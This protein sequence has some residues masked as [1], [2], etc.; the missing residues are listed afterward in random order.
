MKKIRVM[1]VD[2]EVLAIEHIQQLIP[3]EDLGYEIVCTTTRPSQAVELAQQHQPELIIVDIVMPGMDGMLLSKRIQSSGLTVKIVLLTSVK[4]FE[5]AKEAVKLGL[6]NYWVK[7]EMDSATLTRELESLRLEIEKVRRHRNEERKRLLHD[8]LLGTSMSN[9]QWRATFKESGSGLER[10]HMIILQPDRPFPL[11]ASDLAEQST[12]ELN[13]EW[14]E[15]DRE[16]LLAAIRFKGKHFVLLFVDDGWRGEG[17]IREFIEEKASEAR[18]R[19]EEIAG[20]TSSI[21]IVS[22]VRNYQELPLKLTESLRLFKSS[23]FDGPRHTIRLNDIRGEDKL[24]KPFDWEEGVDRI[25][26]FLVKQ[27]FED[28]GEELTALFREAVISRNLICFEDM[29]RQLVVLL[30]RS[31]IA[32]Q[33]PSYQELREQGLLSSSSWIS[34]EGIRLWFLS[35]ME[36]VSDSNRGQSVHSRKVRQALDYM[37]KNFAD[38]DVGADAIAR[39]LG[40]SRDHFRHVFK[41]ETGQTV[42]DQLT[43]I[44]MNNARRLLNEGKYKIYEIAELV[45]YRNSQYFSQVFKKT[46]GMSPLEYME[47]PR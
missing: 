28:A 27:R 17:K 5:Y 10:L 38:E 47:K 1:I 35:E 18:E 13:T 39:H 3:W 31:R 9:E 15:D 2:D 25:G 34:C 43:D 45:G 32:C 6:S 20:G 7:H 16:D 12:L 41:E 19:M 44:R 11:L 22:G 36:Q 29:C 42:L 24:P 37:E 14:P 4:E 26:E 30:N 33:L 21:I 8:W 40:I 23:I 46:M